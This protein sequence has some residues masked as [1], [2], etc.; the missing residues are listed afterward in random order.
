M[1]SGQIR[2]T[3]GRGSSSRLVRCL[4]NAMSRPKIVDPNQTKSFF[5][6][7]TSYSTT[8]KFM[9]YIVNSPYFAPRALFCW[10]I[11]LVESIDSPRNKY[12]RPSGILLCNASVG[13]ASPVNVVYN[14]SSVASLSLSLFHRDLSPDL[15]AKSGILPYREADRP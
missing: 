13:R 10:E 2:G 5:E 15:Y 1:T 7:H 3:V 8:L 4:S 9:T 14:K 11:N 6:N 12:N